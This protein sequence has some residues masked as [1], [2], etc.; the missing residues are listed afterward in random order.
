MLP[1]QA[2]NELHGSTG[3][4]DIARTGQDIKNLDRLGD[5]AEQ[6]IVASLP[7][8][9]L[10]E[11]DRRA[12]GH[13]SSANDRSVEVHRHPRKPEGLQPGQQHLSAQLSKL[14]NPRSVHG[15][16]CST[17]RG[18]I[19]KFFEP[20]KSKHHEIVPVVIHVPQTHIQH[21]MNDQSKNNHMM[22][23]GGVAGHMS[24]AFSQPGLEFQLCK[25]RLN[26][27]QTRKRRESLVFNRSSGILW[28]RL[29][30]CVL[31]YL[32]ISGLLVRLILLLV[33]SILTNQEAVLRRF[34]ATIYE[35]FMQQ[36]GKL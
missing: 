20:Q 5:S 15:R 6:G 28:T 1:M 29:V 21:Q 31:L 17:H 8:L 3:I 36:E 25:Q 30:I 4:M 34:V 33:T 9:L 27:H 16:Q 19:R 22:A 35:Y 7:F 14:Q 18:N 23:K 13:S 24:K 10:V 32:I 2:N 11:P 12:F 26:D